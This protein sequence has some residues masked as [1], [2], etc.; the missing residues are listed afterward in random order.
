MAGIHGPRVAWSPP[1]RQAGVHRSER[2]FGAVFHRDNVAAVTE[3]VF[4]ATLH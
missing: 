1:L 3:T 2:A 4:A